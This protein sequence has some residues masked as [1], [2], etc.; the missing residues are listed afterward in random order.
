MEIDVPEDSN[1]FFLRESRL[2]LGSSLALSLR[3]IF[4]TLVRRLIHTLQLPSVVSNLENEFIM[5]DEYVIK[6]SPSLD[7]GNLNF[8]KT[9]PRELLGSWEKFKLATCYYLHF[10]P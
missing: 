6:V 8:G 9:R 1:I 5:L 10:V 7:P 2:N 3:I 4:K